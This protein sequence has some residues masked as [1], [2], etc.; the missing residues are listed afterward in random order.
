MDILFSIAI[1]YI[2]I[3]TLVSGILKIYSFSY[4]SLNTYGLL[5]HKVNLK[6]IKFCSFLLIFIEVF[7]PLTIFLS[8]KI[9]IWSMTILLLMYIF[10]SLFVTVLIFIG[11]KG[12]ECDCF[13][14]RLTSNINWT[15]VSMNMISVLIISCSFKLD[16]T[17]HVYYIIINSVFLCFYFY[18]KTIINRK[19]R[20]ISWYT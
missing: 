6:L 13:G 20:W 4:F 1:T 17:I 3:Q 18:I 8:L 2:L 12:Q 15:K 7:V 16:I 10:F 11:K 14:T 9:S 5:N 19:G